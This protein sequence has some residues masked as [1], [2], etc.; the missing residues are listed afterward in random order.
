MRT[1]VPTA[2]DLPIEHLRMPVMLVSAE[3]D[4]YLTAKVV[5]Y[6]ARRI[7]FAEVLIFDPVDTSL[8]AKPKCCD[9][10]SSG[11][12]VPWWLGAVDSADGYAI[13]P[14]PRQK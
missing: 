4:P 2:P 9:K 14:M 5:R 7:R 3:D 6:P 10:R 8:W 13:D 11:S 12:L 1:T